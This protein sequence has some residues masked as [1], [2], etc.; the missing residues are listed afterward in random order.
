MENEFPEWNGLDGIVEHDDRRKVC[1]RS[2]V[3]G[4]NDLQVQDAQMR[5]LNNNPGNS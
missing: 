2:P 1:L 4:K 5:L 3:A